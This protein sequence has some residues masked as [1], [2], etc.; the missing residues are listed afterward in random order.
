MTCQEFVELI[1]AFLEGVRDAGSERRLVDHVGMC[2]GCQ[3][4]L[5]QFRHTISS[6]GELPADE[7][8]T[9]LREALLRTFRGSC[10]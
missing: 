3:T 5:D 8:S 2:A 1:T 6:L 10:A 7:L 4:Y 9:G